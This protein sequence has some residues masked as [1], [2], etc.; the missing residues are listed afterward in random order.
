M[1][2]Y[3]N[4]YPRICSFENLLLAAKKAQKGKRFKTNTAEFNFQLERELLTLQQEL[5]SQTYQPG[6]YHEFYIFDPKKRL[7][8]AAPYRDRVIHHALCN[9]IEPIFDK[10]FIYDSYA[11]RKG[12]GQHKAVQRFTQFCQ[13]NKYVLKCDIRKYFPTIDHEILKEKIR[14]K[15]AD[16]KTL[17]LIDLIIDSSNEQ[18]RVE[19]Y[20]WGD[21]LFSQLRRKGIPIGNL[22]SQFFANI[23]LND[24]DHFIKEDLHCRFYIRYC[25]D[26]VILDNEKSRLHEIKTAISTFLEGERL[27]LHPKKCLVFPTRLGTEF[28]GYRIFPTHKRLRKANI[29]RFNK[30]LK[31]LQEQYSRYEI[32]LKEVNQ[33]I[34]SWVGHASH[35]DT[36]NLRRQILMRAVFRRNSV[37]IIHNGLNYPNA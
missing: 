20:F 28:L 18:E 31:Q 10:T 17:W 23:Y 27:R 25:D 33:S 11:C 5:L 34:V 36:H 8:S 4:L 30:R 9:V 2:T 29:R 21:D 26:F 35:A 3:K 14:Q 24:M 15:I 19:Q 16:K 22:T 37:G 6:G 7:I 13:N 32:D 1:K 12:K